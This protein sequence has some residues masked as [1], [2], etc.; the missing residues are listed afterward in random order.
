MIPRKFT[1]FSFAKQYLDARRINV[2]VNGL[3]ILKFI[4]SP[5]YSLNKISTHIRLGD[6]LTD[7]DIV[8][9]IT[10]SDLMRLGFC[11]VAYVPEQKWFAQQRQAYKLARYT[12]GISHYNDIPKKGQGGDHFILYSPIQKA[13]QLVGPNAHPSGY[14]P[15]IKIDD[16]KAPV[17]K[18]E[19][20]DINKYF[21][22]T[23]DTGLTNF[24]Q[25]MQRRIPTLD[26][27]PKYLE[28]P[29]IPLI[30]SMDTNEVVCIPI[31][32][33]IPKIGFIGKTGCLS[34]NTELLI[35]EKEV[36][37]K[38]KI[39][40]L[41]IE[42][43][44][45]EII[46]TDKSGKLSWKRIQKAFSKGM[47]KIK[48][49]WLSPDL[50]IDATADHLFLDINEKGELFDV[51]LSSLKLYNLVPVRKEFAGVEIPFPIHYE[52]LPIKKELFTPQLKRR[53]SKTDRE[54]VFKEK[55]KVHIRR[56]RCGREAFN[57]LIEEYKEINAP[58]Y[59]MI[60]WCQL[61]DN[62]LEWYKIIKI[63]DLPEEEV[64]D[65]QVEDNDT[66]ALYNGIIVHNSGKTYGM[67]SVLDRIKWK[68]NHEIAI[69]NDNS[70]QSFLWT[71]P[72]QSEMQRNYLAKIG[73]E[74]RPL[75]IIPLYPTSDDMNVADMLLKDEIS[76]DISMSFADV[77]E[78]FDYFFEAK[79]NWHLGASDKYF[80]QCKDRI[81]EATSLDQIEEILVEEIGHI[82]GLKPTI[83]KIVSIFRDMLDMNFTDIS[84]GVPAK[85]RFVFNQEG[86]DYETNPVIGLMRTGAIPALITTNLGRKEYFPNYERYY[87]DAIYDA[88]IA[89]T[90]PV[91]MCVDEVGNIYKKGAKKTV[92][93]ESFI[94]ACTEGR[95]RQLG[96][97][98]TIQNY[99]KLDEE[100]RN[101]TNYL[102]SC[103]YSDSKEINLIAKD[104]DLDD[105]RRSELSKLR[106]HEV[107]AMS[108]DRPFV[109][110][111]FD[112][113]RREET[114]VAY[115]G[116]TI[117][118]LSEHRRPGTEITREK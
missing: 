10:Y 118:C 93:A 107:I 114:G 109:I 13:L 53:I 65:I 6:K 110:Y 36:L 80:R 83:G 106:G 68:T 28:I 63:E 88:Q 37:K 33:D 86:Q 31:G 75:P 59:N 108:N 82:K 96:V 101:N 84:S 77:V 116:F 104:F 91:W 100:V 60:K 44:D 26:F 66:F 27:G 98:Y 1:K 117:P 73:E 45:T 112:G 64:W 105:K 15:I 5:E 42:P 39:S 55:L 51:P 17:K 40:D 72:N 54:Y 14:G 48:R 7:D 12:T 103:I 58:I 97:L 95:Q 16:F 4:G 115:K 111:T 46:S 56:G 8:L 76:Q 89:R 32:R 78:H 49:V 11:I 102:L 21:K 22:A 94:K 41:P 18:E 62:D 47:Q 19:K 43:I 50:Y 79:E 74:A 23:T 70:N 71:L 3:E 85:W 99:S 113:E 30:F 35:K 69:L 9:E 57:R 61:N 52:S 20:R 81:R 90:K 92:A 87:M 34:K 2:F 25:Q 24:E 29:E 38:I 67:H